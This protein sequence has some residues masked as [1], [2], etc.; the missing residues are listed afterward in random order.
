MACTLWLSF[1]FLN[2]EKNLIKYFLNTI[3]ILFLVLFFDSLVQYFFGHNLIGLKNIEASR[4][5]S[6][7]GDEQVL[8]GYITR[9]FPFLLLLKNMS[10][11]DSKNKKISCLFCN[12]CISSFNFFKR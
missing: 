5:T 3:V 12:F 10:D 2:E 4:I 6:F 7:F 1:I 9:L 11:E 8:G